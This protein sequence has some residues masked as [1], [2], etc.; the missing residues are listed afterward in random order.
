M[1]QFIYTN[2]Y[3][4]NLLLFTFIK[5]SFS[6]LIILLNPQMPKVDY[7]YKIYTSKHESNGINSDINT[8]AQ[9]SYKCVYI[10]I[11]KMKFYI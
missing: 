1:I 3:S 6:I 2:M 10:Y 4:N 9:N 7:W 11:D 5:F 8:V